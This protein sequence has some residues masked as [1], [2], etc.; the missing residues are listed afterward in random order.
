MH[1]SPITTSDGRTRYVVL[2]DDGVLVEPI[3]RYLKHLDL[4][5]Y[6]RNTLRTYATHLI[7]FFTF[8]QQRSLDFDHLTIDD[9]AAFVQWLKLPTSSAPAPRANRTINHI[10]TAVSGLYDYFW[11][12]DA[13]PLDF[14]DRMR[15]YLSP[16]ARSY[17]NLL[18]HLIKDQPVETHLFTQPVPKCRP[19]TL[20][21]AQI[22]SLVAHC[23]QQR[24]RL[25]LHLLYESSLRIGE[26]LALWLEDI[27]V[28]R[29]QFHV[30]NRGELVNQAELKSDAAERVV[31]VSAELIASILDYVA[32]T[33]TDAVTTN[34]LWLFRSCRK[35]HYI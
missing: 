19:K 29:Y 10:L 11:R 14:N 16:R 34:H 13:L 27:D 5:G 3:V 1:L 23:A 4:R 33:H 9:L 26:A 32:V 28:A 24:D 30:R 22:E 18:Y 25:L 7:L 15:L 17:K 20:T 35:Q 2:D 31:D 12:R 21:K 6:A 8:L